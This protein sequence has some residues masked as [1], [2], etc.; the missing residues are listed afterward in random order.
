M[1]KLII[2]M[3]FVIPSF[4]K[5][6]TPSSDPNK[7]EWPNHRSCTN[8]NMKTHELMTAH[9]Y[10][11]VGGFVFAVPT[12][13]VTDFCNRMLDRLSD[14]QDGMPI[15]TVTNEIQETIKTLN[16]QSRYLRPHEA[17]QWISQQWMGRKVTEI[18]G[19]RRSGIVTD[20]MWDE[21][22][23]LHCYMD[24]WWCPAVKLIPEGR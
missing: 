14:I 4:T 3:K 7:A 1:F 20:T 21:K 19:D 15:N 11:A 18:A 24:N 16:A 5:S 22:G 2:K 17:N 8:P 12:C 10:E 6:P 13:D 9:E 23:A